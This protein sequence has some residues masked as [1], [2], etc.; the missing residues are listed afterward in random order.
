MATPLEG[1][2]CQNHK[3]QPWMAEGALTRTSTLRI[4]SGR[5]RN[6]TEPRGSSAGWRV[7]EVHS[8]RPDTWQRRPRCKVGCKLSLLL[9]IHFFSFWLWKHQHQ[10]SSQEASP[11]PQFHFNPPPP[12]MSG[13]CSNRNG[14]QIILLS[15]TR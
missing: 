2:A 3:F 4:P 14:N 5:R 8:P 10:S 11:K 12:Q 13:L 9:F 1:G 7:P 15:R 6:P